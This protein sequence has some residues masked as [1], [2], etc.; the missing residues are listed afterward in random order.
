MA[1][2]TDMLGEDPQPCPICGAL[3]RRLE[4][5]DHG[6]WHERLVDEVV[7]AVK[8]RLSDPPPNEPV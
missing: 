6:D 2:P 8:V 7:T 1:G 5:A 3:V 4:A